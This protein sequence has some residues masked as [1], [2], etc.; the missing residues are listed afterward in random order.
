M[1]MRFPKIFAIF[2]FFYSLLFSQESLRRVPGSPYPASQIPDTLY[3]IEDYS[4]SDSQVFTLQTLQGLLAKTKPMIYR[5]RGAGHSIWFDDLISNYGIFADS[6]YKN[7]F[8]GIISHFKDRFEGYILCDLHNNSSNVALSIC[9]LLKTIAVTPDDVELMDSLS[10]PKI[11]DVRDQDEE[12]ALDNYDSLLST[13][14]VTYQK[15]NKDLFLGDYSIFANALH[16]FDNINS[17]L[18]KTAFGRMD[19]S[20]SLFGWGSDE[21]NTVSEASSNSIHV[22]PADWAINLS[23]LSNFD[24]A[25]EQKSGSE[26]IDYEKNVQTV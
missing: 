20:S 6:S 18:T 11:M 12:W 9:G 25:L 24:I 26:N 21:V 13:K 16:F 22:H 1:K 2:L 23:T 14:I 3:I 8:A 15:E 10:I 5:D 4:F 17:T 7:D 19:K